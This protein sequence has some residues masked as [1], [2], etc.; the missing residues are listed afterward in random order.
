MTGTTSVYFLESS[1]VLNYSQVLLSLEKF[2][3]LVTVQVCR[4][5]IHPRLSPPLGGLV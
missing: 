2:V 3:L 5:V 4:S 1:E